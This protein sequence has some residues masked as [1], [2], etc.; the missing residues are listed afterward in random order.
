MAALA[1]VPVCILAAYALLT[2]GRQRREFVARVIAGIAA[3]ILF[4]AMYLTFSRA[5]ILSLFGLAV[6]VAWRLNRR[7]G[8]VVLLGGIVAGTALFPSYVALRSQVGAGVSDPGSVAVAS[9]ALRLQA[10]DSAFHMWLAEPIVGQGFLAYKQLA[11]SYGDPVLSSPHNEWL[12]L[13]AEEG[14]VAGIVG[15][16]FVATLLKRLARRHD[17]LASGIL[18]GA[19][20]YILMAS[21]NNPFLFIQ[22][23]TVV[24]TAVGF[25]LARPPIQPERP[26]PAQSESGQD[27]GDGRR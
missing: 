6:V 24:F 13:F 19:F 3:A 5:A 16:A 11:D 27:D 22:V 4:L 12:R 25:G 18:A 26:S 20:G 14:V 2:S 17:L 1:V 10:W 7:L 8:M 21:F 9:D 15:L 23:S